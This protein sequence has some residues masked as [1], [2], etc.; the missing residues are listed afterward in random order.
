MNRFILISVFMLLS[1][2]ACSQAGL[3]LGDHV[4]PIVVSKWLYGEPVTEFKPGML[5][6]IEFTHLNCKPCREAIPSLTRL[7]EKYSNRLKVIGLYS[8]FPRENRDEVVY[9]RQINALRDRLGDQMNYTVALDKP[10]GLMNKLWNDGGGFPKAY[11]LDSYGKVIW[12]GMGDFN[13]LDFVIK[14]VT[15]VGTDA[16]LLQERQNAFTEIYQDVMKNRQTRELAESLKKIDSIMTAFPEREAYNLRL[17][18]YVLLAKDSQRATSFLIKTQDRLPNWTF[19]S[20][21]LDYVDTHGLSDKRILENFEREIQNNIKD[22]LMVADLLLAKGRY[23]A[24]NGYFKQAADVLSESEYARFS[25]S[26]PSGNMMEMTVGWKQTALFGEVFLY[27]GKAA[28][29][30]LD[31]YISTGS[32][33]YFATTTI[34]RTFEEKL[35]D[36]QED[37]LEVYLKKQMEQRR[38]AP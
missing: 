29:H 38:G 24:K 23:L 17:M 19:N 37:L 20:R 8:Y 16:A 9:A 34:M 2:M 32:L 3:E 15:E 21:M 6:L 26:V 35:S 12:V 30:W 27:G 22:T 1:R 5:Y 36:E 14:Q 7:A 13:Q 18:F 31:Y 4:P 28:T 11:L 10:G 33:T 25:W